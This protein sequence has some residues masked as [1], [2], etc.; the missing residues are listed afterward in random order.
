MLIYWV[1][2]FQILSQNLAIHKEV[3]FIQISPF[4][5]IGMICASFWLLS[6]KLNIC[7]KIV[8]SQFQCPSVDVSWSGALLLFWFEIQFEISLQQKDRSWPLQKFALFFFNVLGNNR[9]SINAHFAD[10]FVKNVRVW[11]F[12]L[13]FLTILINFSKCRTAKFFCLFHF[14]FYNSISLI[15][16]LDVDVNVVFRCSSRCFSFNFQLSRLQF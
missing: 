10:K 16:P 15:V 12:V 13:G 7:S 1:N 5:R 2:F 8:F 14:A 4:L 11:I 6:S 3:V 9:S